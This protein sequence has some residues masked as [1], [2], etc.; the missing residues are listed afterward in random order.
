M[1][2]TPNNALRWT[3]TGPL[4]QCKLV[5]MELPVVAPPSATPSPSKS[6]WAEPGMRRVRLLLWHLFQR[7]PLREE[8]GLLHEFAAARHCG[9]AWED[10]SA[11]KARHPDL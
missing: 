7:T 2:T 1:T 4:S 3:G 6:R 11:L 9:I 8:I 5:H 10:Y